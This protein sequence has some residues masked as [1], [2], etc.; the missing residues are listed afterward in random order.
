MILMKSK[1]TIGQPGFRPDLSTGALASL[2]I[3]GTCTLVFDLDHENFLN[4]T[5]GPGISQENQRGWRKLCTVIVA[6]SNAVTSTG[7]SIKAFFS[8][9]GT[10]TDQVPAG[11]SYNNAGGQLV[12]SSDLALTTMQLLVSKRFL[13]IVIANGTTAAQGA[14]TKCHI[15]TLDM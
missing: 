1:D 3:S 14:T 4:Q 7:G 12:Y 15:A 13:R 6:L 8:D 2:A 9:D 11:A 5:M 10:A